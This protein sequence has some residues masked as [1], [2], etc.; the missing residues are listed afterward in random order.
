MLRYPEKFSINGKTGKEKG[1]KLTE[2]TAMLNMDMVGRMRE[3]KLMAVGTATGDKFKAMIESAAKGMELKVNVEARAA[4]G[5]DQM[6]FHMKKIPAIHF[7]TG[8]HKDYHKPTDTA[9][10]I[11][12]EGAVKTT[13]L[14]AVMV[15]NYWQKDVKINYIKARMAHPAKGGP[16]GFGAYLGVIPN[17]ASLDADDGCAIDG[18]SDNSPAE[19]A[20][21]K[22]DDVIIA[23]G[24]TKIKN[25]RDLTDALRSSKPGQKVKLT[26]KRKGKEINLTAKIGT[27]G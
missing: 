19:D 11:N 21:L 14:L 2:F 20:G 15:L 18:V 9:E 5:S 3:N 4:G 27:R 23:W 17:Y 6:S 1:I 10:K 12:F 7:F 24:K 22:G 25:L 13:N 8:A 26:V 16:R